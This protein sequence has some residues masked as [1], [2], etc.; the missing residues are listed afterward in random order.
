MRIFRLDEVVGA[1]VSA[2][3]R[4]AGTSAEDGVAT[5]NGMFLE[6]TGE[7]ERLGKP[8]SFP[9]TELPC[10]LSRSTKNGAGSSLMLWSTTCRSGTSLDRDLDSFN[11]RSAGLRLSRDGLW[12][13]NR[14]EDLLEEAPRSGLGVGKRYVSDAFESGEKPVC[15][16]SGVRLLGTGIL[17]L[18]EDEK[19]VE[20]G[21]SGVDRVRARRV[22]GSSRSMRGEGDVDEGDGWDEVGVVKPSPRVPDRFLVIN[23][24]V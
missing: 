8:I 19:S 24:L 1:I 14:C 22:L 5:A 6:V 11:S 2:R 4:T 9:P 16:R 23:G 7:S 13:T 12:S 20:V 15:E 10:R 18:G 21:L 3:L 17:V